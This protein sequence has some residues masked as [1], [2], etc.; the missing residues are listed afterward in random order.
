MSCCLVRRWSVSRFIG[1][2]LLRSSRTST[3]PGIKGVL[4]SLR[5]SDRRAVGHEVVELLL[6]LDQ[7]LVERLVTRITYTLR[8]LELAHEA[9]QAL[10]QCD[11]P[12]VQGE[13][14]KR[15]FGDL[16]LGKEARHHQLGQLG[17]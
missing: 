5:V 11:L 1:R 14:L 8:L 10:L 2:A 3:K 17:G 6:Q 12:Q 4:R 15:V 16:D 7:F 9:R 13:L